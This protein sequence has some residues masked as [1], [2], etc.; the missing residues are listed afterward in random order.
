MLKGSRYSLA[1]TALFAI[2][3][4]LSSQL[5]LAALHEH[6]P[7]CSPDGSRMIY[8]LKSEQ[9]KGDWELYMLSFEDQVISRLTNHKGW[10]G[11]AVW[12]PDGT[13]IIY[14][15]ADAP[16]ERNRPWIM[17]V[18]GRTKK[19]L[20][21]HE[22]W[23]SVSDWSK[24]NRL[25]GFLELNGQRDLVML[26]QNGNVKGKITETDQ[27]SEHDAHFSPDGK[28]IAY[29]SGT[30]EGN[31]TTLELIDL[32]SGHKTIL[33]SSIGRIYGINW[34]PDGE[35]I[36][37]VDAPAGADDDADIFV[38]ATADQS[39]KQVTDDP[40]WDHMPMFCDDSKILI[41][42]SDRS[43]EERIYRVDTEPRLYLKVVPAL[44]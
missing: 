27:Y 29:A 26:D 28:K 44:K 23:L 39:F 15:R 12:S 22:G 34:S 10:D 6:R 18:E 3:F 40:S 25:L 7:V 24:D 41:F 36:A 17:D 42:T 31:K 14:D 5:A 33:R 20:G 38:Y 16:G 8:M 21:Q 30:I 37:F 32:E 9:T 43:G 1:M 35:K 19:P 2:I 4:L 11:Y 13:R